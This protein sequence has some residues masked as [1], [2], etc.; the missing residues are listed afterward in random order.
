MCSE[1]AHVRFGSKADIRTAKSEVRFYSKSGHVQ[2]TS[3]VRWANSGHGMP[4]R[5]QSTKLRVVINTKSAKTLGLTIPPDG[6]PLL[7]QPW[8]RRYAL[9]H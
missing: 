1:Q 7:L 6:E 4:I 3:P 2:C 5:S 9:A 8:R